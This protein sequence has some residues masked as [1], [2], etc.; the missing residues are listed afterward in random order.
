MASARIEAISASRTDGVAIG[1]PIVSASTVRNG[2]DIASREDPDVAAA[3]HFQKNS[4]WR[5]L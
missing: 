3:M 1:E 2:V 5:P 4:V